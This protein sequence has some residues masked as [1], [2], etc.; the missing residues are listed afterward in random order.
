MFVEVPLFQETS[1]T[2]KNSWLRPLKIFEN[3]DYNI[4]K[5]RAIEWN[6]SGYI[7]KSNYYIFIKNIIACN[8][9]YSLT[10]HISFYRYACKYIFSNL[11]I[12][13]TYWH[14]TYPRLLREENAAQLSIKYV[15]M[16]ILH[17]TYVLAGP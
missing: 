6:K 7:I 9:T 2:L 3:K 4:Y 16:R 10:T 1:T 13:Q 11:K 8:S 12:S 14:N 17:L 5:R 15:E